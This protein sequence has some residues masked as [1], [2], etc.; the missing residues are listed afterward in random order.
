MTAL[1]HMSDE[2]LKALGIPMVRNN[3]SLSFFFFF[4]VGLES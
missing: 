4:G 2:D 1:L 3:W